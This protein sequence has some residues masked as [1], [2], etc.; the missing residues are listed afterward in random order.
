MNQDN[1]CRYVR[2]R[3]QTN[4]GSPNADNNWCSYY[5]DINGGEQDY[6]GAH[7]I[8][9][10]GFKNVHLSHI[11]IFNAGQPRV[12][13]YPF[14]WHHA[15]YAGTRGGYD[16]PSSIDSLS[17]HD[18]FSRWATIHGT[19]EATISNCVGYNTFGHGFFLE[20]G[21]ESYNSFIGNLGIL[22]KPGIILPSERSNSICGTTGDGYG[23]TNYDAG[24]HC[25][26]LSVFWFANIHNHVHDNVA[27]G[28]NA[29]YWLFTHT[30]LRSRDTN[31]STLKL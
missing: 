8:V 5:N 26:G 18:A 30:G 16:D 28:G 9:T 29:G 7:S 13:R 22:V 1:G 6:H 21:F 3:E 14:H 12:G 4:A 15:G 2:T 19:H 31:T 11:E 25:E 23:Y 24:D 10:S 20:D 17:I 27:V